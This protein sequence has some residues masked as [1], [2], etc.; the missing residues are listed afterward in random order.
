MVDVAAAAGVSTA[1]VSI[2]MRDVPGASAETRHHVRRVAAELGYVPDRRAQKL[3]Q[4]RSGLIGVAFELQQPFQGDVVEQLYPAAAEGGYDLMLSG[5]VPTRGEVE[6]AEVLVRERCEVV[7]LL[8]S[9]RAAASLDVLA[10]RIPALVVARPSGTPRVG[11]VRMDDIRGMRV[12][13]DHLVGLGHR[14]ILYIDGADAPGAAERLTGFAL[15]VAEHGLGDDAHV[16]PG[17]PSEPD[18]VRAMTAV[19]EG[20]RRRPTAVLAFNDRCAIGVLDVL[21]RRRIDVPGEVS[22]IGYD[23]S[24]LSRMDHIGLSTVAQDAGRIAE[25]VVAQVVRRLDGGPPEDVVL[26]PSLVV[27]TTAGPVGGRS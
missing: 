27:R 24:R 10:E 14:G 2:V 19:L 18:G 9:R 25:E 13:V 3:R 26:A 8:G 6:A 15:G 16:V 5:V 7:V 20:D 22:V 17:G 4:S 23:D 1:L 12:A 21:L 11:A